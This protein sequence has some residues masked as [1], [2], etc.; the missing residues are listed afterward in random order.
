MAGQNNLRTGNPIILQPKASSKQITSF[1]LINFRMLC[2]FIRDKD[3]LTH[4]ANNTLCYPMSQDTNFC[5][6]L[7]HG[8]IF[9]VLNIFFERQLAF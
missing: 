6:P 2:N 4:E 9:I 8:Y 1:I 5:Y 3:L 7:N